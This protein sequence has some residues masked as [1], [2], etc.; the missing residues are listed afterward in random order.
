MLQDGA[1]RLAYRLPTM[2][3]CKGEFGACFLLG[4]GVHRAEPATKHK[5]ALV[6]S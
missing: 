1:M 4:I 2:N 3:L 5:S 6:D